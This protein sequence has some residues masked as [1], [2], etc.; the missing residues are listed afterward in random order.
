MSDTADTRGP[1][2]S[3]TPSLINDMRQR[4]RRHRRRANI[5]AIFSIGAI[6]VCV[7]VFIAAEK[8]SDFLFLTSAER[9]ANTALTEAKAEIYKAIADLGDPAADMIR[10]L[11]PYAREAIAEILGI[12][13]LGSSESPQ[14]A[15]S[16]E[17][18]DTEVVSRKDS[19]SISSLNER[20][21]QLDA[22]FNIQQSRISDQA[23]EIENLRSLQHGRAGDFK[24]A[25]RWIR[26]I[27]EQEI[28]SSISASLP[29]T[30][31]P[32]MQTEAEKAAVEIE[33]IRDEIGINWEKVY[34]EREIALAR[35]DAEL[36]AKLENAD[37]AAE[38]IFAEEKKVETIAEFAT[39]T[40]T[41]AGSL[42]ML[43]WLVRIFEKSRRRHEGLADFYQAIGDAMQLDRQDGEW[44]KFFPALLPSG[45][46][47]AGDESGTDREV[48][49]VLKALLKR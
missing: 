49:E 45:A 46:S 26:Q 23:R 15:T 28:K 20:V 8:L 22:L 37:V 2:A 27:V 19:T 35:I 43:V 6:V 7:S 10:D 13:G 38:K 30:G 29:S 11:P 24:G 21:N 16:G 9:Q 48:L 5:D 40:L 41:R 32:S 3:P 14:D 18:A 33:K 34:N 36:E 12:P 44:A 1:D 4:A 42:F 17:V 25:E 47:A 31:S 39:T